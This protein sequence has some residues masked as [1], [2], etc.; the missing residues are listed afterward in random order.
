MRG[1][2]FVLTAAALVLTAAAWFGSPLV[3][4]ALISGALQNAGFQATTM[5][6][7]A[8]SNPPPKLLLGRMDRVEIVAR[9]ISLR[10]FHAAGLDLVLTDLDLAARSAGRISGRIDGAQL[11]IAGGEVT[12]ADIRIDGEAAAAGASMLVSGAAVEGAVKAALGRQ[13]GLSVTGSTLIAPD[14]L[15]V[16]TVIGTVEGR[17]GVD[18]SGAIALSTPLGSAVLLGLDPSVPLRLTSIVVEAGDLR[19]GAVLDVQALLSGG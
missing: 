15:R 5:T 14:V 2:L 19:I 13:L 4:D 6:V 3:A 7:S 16:T 11:T 8:T 9:G 12:S 17:L 1:C 10:T 18:A